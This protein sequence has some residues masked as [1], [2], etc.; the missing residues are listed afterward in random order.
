VTRRRRGVGASAATHAASGAERVRRCPPAA[1]RT[2]CSGV[3][4]CVA[5]AG[6]RRDLCRSRPAVS[7]F[8][9]RRD[10]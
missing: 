9:A 5:G 2:A 3:L 10:G 7:T 6:I 8:S 4:A 1:D